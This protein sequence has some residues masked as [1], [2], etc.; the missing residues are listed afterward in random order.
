MGAKALWWGI[1]GDK[2]GNVG[3]GQNVVSL[4]REQC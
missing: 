3:S 4:A 2:A 1:G